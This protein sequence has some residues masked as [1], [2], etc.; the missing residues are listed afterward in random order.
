MCVCLSLESAPWRP[1]CFSLSYVHLKGAD[2]NPGYNFLICCHLRIFSS[3]FPCICC[4]HI[5]LVCQCMC[6]VCMCGGV[7]VYVGGPCTQSG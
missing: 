3:P 4:M 1:D 5:Q 2:I 7:G 6:T